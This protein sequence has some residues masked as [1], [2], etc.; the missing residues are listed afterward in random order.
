MSK[1]QQLR[2]SEVRDIYRLVG[3]CR[4]LGADSLTWRHHALERLRNLIGAQVGEGGESAAPI[5]QGTQW[6]IQ[7]VDRGWDSLHARRC[8]EAYHRDQ[9]L[10]RDPFVRRFAL[11]R[12]RLTTRSPEQVLELRSWQRSIAFNEYFRAAGFNAGLLSQLALAG[13]TFSSFSFHRSKEAPLFGRR[14]RRLVHLFHQ[15]IGPLVGRSLAGAREPAIADLAPRVRQ[16]LDC[17]LEG[18]SEKQA[19]MRLGLSQAT[20]HEYVGTLYRH[21]GVSSRAELLA[22]FL[23]RFRGGYPVGK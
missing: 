6:F 22:Y 16:T 7:F 18:D 1:S 14:E 13:G 11:L 4:E 5:H 17:L 21:F 8:A 2:L 12:G 9:M 3:E 10:S 15:E 23:R 20:V 19:A